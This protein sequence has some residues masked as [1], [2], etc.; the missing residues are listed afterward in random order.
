VAQLVQRPP[1]CLMEQVGGT[2]VRQPGPPADRVEVA[3]RDRKGRCPIG[4]EHGAAGPPGDQAGKQPGGWGLPVD[5]LDRAAL[6]HHPGP[7]VGQ[8]EVGDI[9]VE[10]LAGPAAV[11]YISSH[12]VLSRSRRSLRRHSASSWAWVRSGCSR[13]RTSPAV[14]SLWAASQPCARHQVTAER[15]VAS[16]RFQVAGAT[17]A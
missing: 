2:P 12:K 17:L 4:E 10:R 8:V 1:C 6:G 9:E 3:G 13:R 5:P 11:S 16:S 14:G 15:S 7:L